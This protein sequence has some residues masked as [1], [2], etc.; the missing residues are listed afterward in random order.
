MQDFV[1]K[2]KVLFG[3]M[4]IAYFSVIN[5]YFW[6]DWGDTV[7]LLGVEVPSYS[8]VWFWISCIAILMGS[9]FMAHRVR[10]NAVWFV[11][12]VWW[13]LN[14]LMTTF[15]L[16]AISHRG[17]GESN[18]E[19]AGTPDIY[20]D[21]WAQGPLDLLYLVGLFVILR[22][23]VI[24]TTPLIVVFSFFLV[25]NIAGHAFA[26]YGLDSG[27]SAG[28]VTAK[29]DPFMYLTFTVMLLV[30]VGGVLLDSTLK[31]NGYANGVYND[32]RP[33]FNNAWNR[34]IHF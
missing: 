28:E 26:A 29:Y 32:L 7:S 23:G 20:Y 9:G 21:L 17:I 13:T 4:F 31:L 33:F 24:V 27:I 3:F 19:I 34:H 5:K 30:Q 15:V 18:T 11:I 22:K 12:S 16:E 1:L 6:G 10:E 14:T 25:T 2:T 8:L